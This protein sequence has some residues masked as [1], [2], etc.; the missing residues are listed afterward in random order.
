M[1]SAGLRKHQIKAPLP[2]GPGSSIPSLSPHTLLWGFCEQNKGLHSC[3]R[4]SLS[5]S[6]ASGRV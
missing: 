1:E 2:P 6:E 5:S 3:N 4:C